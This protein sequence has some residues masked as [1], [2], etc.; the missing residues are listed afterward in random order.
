M[1]GVSRGCQ[2][3]RTERRKKKHKQERRLRGPRDRGRL[4]SRPYPTYP[5]LSPPPAPEK[6]TKATT[7]GLARSPNDKRTLT[8]THRGSGVMTCHVKPSHDGEYM[9]VRSASP[10]P[11]PSADD[12]NEINLQER[13][14]FSR[15]FE[16][17]SEFYTYLCYWDVYCTTLLSAHDKRNDTALLRAYLFTS[18]G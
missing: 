15:T 11:A 5:H 2:H 4:R 14:S 17:G 16:W 13:T 7:K 6:T 18:T 1:C 9:Y 10:R 12:E 8:T 3:Q